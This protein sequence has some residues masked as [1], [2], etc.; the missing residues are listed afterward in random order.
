MPNASTRLHHR[1]SV[2]FWF[3]CTD[4]WPDALDGKVCFMLR[5]EKIE[6]HHVSLGIFSDVAG[7]SQ[8]GNGSVDI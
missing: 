4:T 7:P 1:E 6:H 8:L 5:F 2:L 3:H